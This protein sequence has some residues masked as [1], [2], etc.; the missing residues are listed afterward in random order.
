MSP[1]IW[2]LI[3][4]DENLKKHIIGDKTTW[5]PDRFNYGFTFERGK[6]IHQL[7]DYI[8]KGK[9]GN[10]ID[11]LIYA[12]KVTTR[13]LNDGKIE[14]IG[15]KGPISPKGYF[16]A[17]FASAVRAGIISYTRKNKKNILSKGPNF[18]EFKKGNLRPL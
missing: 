5:S 17:F 14:Y 2:E 3:E 16:S 13:K 11:F 12:G 7:V 18:E 15:K 9:E 6:L 8:D 1:R 4:N 10:A